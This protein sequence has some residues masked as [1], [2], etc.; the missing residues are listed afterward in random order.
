MAESA[1]AISEGSITAAS[2]TDSS[3]FF[4]T[5]QPFHL[6]VALR[7]LDTYPNV[8][9]L[10]SCFHDGESPRLRCIHFDVSSGISIHA[11]QLAQDGR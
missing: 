7:Y 5:S 9:P 8:M 4:R 2:T 10:P 11:V 3:R 1:G 6:F